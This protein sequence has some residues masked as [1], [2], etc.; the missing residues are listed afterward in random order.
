M[1]VPILRSLPQHL[2]FLRDCHS[3]P[4]AFPILWYGRAF[5]SLCS[6]SE[7]L[8]HILRMQSDSLPTLEVYLVCI[9]LSPT[10]PAQMK[11]YFSWTS[12]DTGNISLVILMDSQAFAILYWLH[13]SPVCISR[14]LYVFVFFFA[15]SL[16]FLFT[17]RTDLHFCR[18]SCLMD[19]G[20]L[21]LHSEQDF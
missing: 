21:C 19:F 9:R 20:I 6:F 10:N 13:S 14:H 8:A 5:C 11:L 17:W 4:S 2:S 15:A 12:E 7:Y 1:M 18:Y 3:S 16:L